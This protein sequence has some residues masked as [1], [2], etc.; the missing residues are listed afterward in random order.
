[1]VDQAPLHGGNI[2]AAAQELG[3]SWRDILDFSANINPLGPPPGLKKR[4]FSTF[5][6]V[7]N[8][9]D[10]LA[11]AWR[12][13]L[14]QKIGLPPDHIA[15]GNGTTGQMYVLARVLRP[16]RPVVVAPAFAEYEQSLARIGIK[17][18]QAGCRLS[19]NFDLTPQVADR[20]FKFEPDAV[21]LAN[22]TSP[23]GRLIDPEIMDRVL[24]LADRSGATV[25]LDEAF[26]D[27][28]PAVGLAAETKRR[29]NLVVFRSL[30]KFYALPGLRLGY[31]TAAPALTRR[32]LAETEPWAVN[33]LALE[34]GS[35]CL[36]Q[37]D[38][39][40]RT[41]ALVDRERA[42]LAGSLEDAGLGRV[43]MGAANYLLVKVEVPGLTVPDLSQ[44]L[45]R[46]GILIRDCSTFPG[47]LS[48]Y[49]R[50]AVKNRAANRK[51]VQAAAEVVAEYNR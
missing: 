21:Y 33:A 20:I 28:T 38:Y 30:T 3:V 44:A 36:H 34:A 46:R 51:L 22:P 19:E 11:E 41:R 10:P 9:P 15:A 5:G 17:P 45:R 42:W 26:V 40:R 49:I 12:R 31:M 7:E 18:K 50:V 48:G 13:E 16:R 37:D 39:A 24:T 32:V 8:Y 35:Y 1:M 27:F 23:A 6:L 47:R 29:K 4:L 43:I 25:I 14:G 2:Y